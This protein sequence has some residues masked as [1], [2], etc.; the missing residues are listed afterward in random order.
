MFGLDVVV[1]VTLEASRTR[2]TVRKRAGWSQIHPA[3]TH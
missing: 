2:G 3:T 1:V